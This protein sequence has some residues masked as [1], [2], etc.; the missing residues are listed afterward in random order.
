MMVKWRNRESTAWGG[1]PD[2]AGDFQQ[3][4]NRN[5][6]HPGNN[7]ER[8]A[9][10]TAEKYLEALRAA[11]QIDEASLLA[12]QSR[13]DNEILDYISTSLDTLNSVFD[14]GIIVSTDSNPQTN[15][16]LNHV[17][18]SKPKEPTSKAISDALKNNS[19]DEINSSESHSQNDS[20]NESLTEEDPSFHTIN[21]STL[22][23]NLN[24]FN[25]QQ[26]HFLHRFPFISK[27]VL[28]G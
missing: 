2:W 3:L 1:Q 7:I 5:E 9:Y 6:E 18:F 4:L 14:S 11:T 26:A 13:K 22:N 23:L 27:P 21:N 15:F 19:S 25:Q 10:E 12:A 8:K 17:H 20:D 16:L 24:G 28:V